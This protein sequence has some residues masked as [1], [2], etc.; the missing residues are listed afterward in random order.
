MAIITIS[1]KS[2]GPYFIS[3]IP[4]QIE[5]STNV[6]SLIFYTLDDSEPSLSSLVYLDPIDLPTENTVRVRVLAISGSDT[7]IL[8]V[9]FGPDN[10][11]LFYP[12][13]NITGSLGIAIDAYGVEPVVIDGYGVNDYNIVD[14]PVRRSDYPLEDLEIR[15]STTGPDGYGPGTMITLGA[16]PAEF[17]QDNAVSEEASSPNHMNVFFNPRSLYIVIDGRDG[18]DDESV[19]PINRPW[20]GTLNPVKYL[21]G[22]QFF[23]PAPFVSGGF[24]RSFINYN[25]GVIILYY[26]DNVETRWIKSIQSF[27]TST[28]PR[29][30]GDRT[31]TGGPLVVPWIYNRR[32]M[33]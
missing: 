5:L 21:Q 10:S 29:R 6:P 11:K 18:Y 22:K 17:W 7:G 23:D 24:V 14:N 20:G 13:R 19:Y 28:V 16:Y 31:Q 30:I 4:R 3:G 12:R 33:I 1:L 32:S 2:L 8:D 9:T 15:Y 26:Y 25:T 27:D